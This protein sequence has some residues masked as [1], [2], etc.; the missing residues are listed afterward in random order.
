[1]DAASHTSLR[2]GQI[3]RALVAGGAVIGLL[4][5]FVAR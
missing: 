2:V 1:M 3:G 4:L 5:V